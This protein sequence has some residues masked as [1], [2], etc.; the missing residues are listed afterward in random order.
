ML[1]KLFKKIE[2]QPK[3][4]LLLD[5]IGAIVST[6]ILFI[7]YFFYRKTFGLEEK[8]FFPLAVFAVSL[9]IFSISCFCFLSKNFIKLLKIISVANLVYCLLILIFLINFE[10][11]LTIVGKIYFS[12]ELIV[13]SLL[14][15]LEIKLI[16]KTEKLQN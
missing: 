15:F 9:S 7:I 16:R 11:E 13:I 3:N 1:K 14:V 10:K 12:V 2:S 5:G 4:I 8:M 6:I